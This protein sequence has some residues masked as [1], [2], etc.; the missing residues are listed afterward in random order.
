MTTYLHHPDAPDR[1]IST[2]NPEYYDGWTRLPKAEG[3]RR[4]VE[5]TRRDL[6][7]WTRPGTRVY[8]ILRKV[9]ASGM[10]RRLTVH[11]VRSGAI[12]DITHAAHVLTNYPLRD[13]HLVIGGCGF[14]AGH[15][16]VYSLGQALWPRGTPEPHSTR[17]G[18]PDRS[19][20]YA[21]KHEWL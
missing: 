7:D 3:L 8:T 15:A 13:G 17:N 19:G 21:L 16:V 9:S 11:A 14:D 1:V 5:G 2:S 18:E 20:G 6:L 12:A 4:Y 10:S